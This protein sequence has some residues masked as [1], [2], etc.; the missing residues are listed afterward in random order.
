MISV[1]DREG[2]IEEEK[3]SRKTVFDVKPQGEMKW[4]KRSCKDAR[5]E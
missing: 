1:E 4:K 2:E 3:R 5:V